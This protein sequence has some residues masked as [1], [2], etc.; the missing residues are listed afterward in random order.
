VADHLSLE[1]VMIED[2]EFKGWFL[3]PKQDP[4]VKLIGPFY[5][6]FD[7]AGHMRVAMKVDERHMNGGGIMHGGSMLSLADTALFAFAV[8]DLEGSR[9]V[10]MQLDSQFLSPGNV[11]DI[12]I[13]TGEVVRSGRTT[14]FA[15]GM[16]HVGDKPIMAFSGVIRKF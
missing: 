3:S 6:Q 16:L 4:Y 10:T 8:G 9:G 1:P 12:V 7:D 14:I 2:G 11:G 15:R 13:A 5:Y